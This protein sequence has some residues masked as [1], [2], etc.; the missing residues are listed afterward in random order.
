MYRDRASASM[1]VVP[2]FY[3][4]LGKSAEYFAIIGAITTAFFAFRATSSILNGLFSYFLSGMLGLSLN[5][6][7]AGSW[8]GNDFRLLSSS[9]SSV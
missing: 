5:L 7:N 2:A 8:A 6:K 9:V 1:A 3:N 4:Y